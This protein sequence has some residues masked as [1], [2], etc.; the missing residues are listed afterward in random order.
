[1]ISE[2]E[3]TNWFCKTLIWKLLLSHLILNYSILLKNS[4]TRNNQDVS[5]HWME[6]HFLYVNLIEILIA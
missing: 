5:I 2:I 4:V 3:T 1:M 6:A